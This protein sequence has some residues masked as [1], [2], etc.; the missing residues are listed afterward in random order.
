MTRQTRHL[1]GAFAAMLV[2]GLSWGANLPV[3]KVMLLH[4]D[5]IPMAAVRTVAA[6]VSLALLLWM[7][8]G[9]EALRIELRFG[10]FVALGFI[11]ATFFAVY[12]LGLSWSNPITAAAIQVAGPLVAAVTVRI[13]VGQRFDAGFGTALALTLAGGAIMS[14]SSLFGRGSVTYGGGQIILL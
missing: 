3:T 7:V 10:R 14:S 4:F 6:A 11:Q 12:A 13:S 1:A 8:E 2:V 5:L 9:A